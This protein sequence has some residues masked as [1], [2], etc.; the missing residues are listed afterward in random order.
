MVHQL[1]TRLSLF[2]RTIDLSKEQNLDGDPK[3]IKQIKF[4]GNLDWDGNTQMFF[5][6]EEAKKTDLDFSKKKQLKY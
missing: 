1:I 2:Q 4:N 5:I 6:T 3:V